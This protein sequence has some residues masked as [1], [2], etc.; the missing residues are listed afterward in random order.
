MKFLRTF[1][2]ALLAFMVGTF[3][4][5]FLWIL[6]VVGFVAMMGGAGDKVKQVTPESVLVIDCNELIVDSP[7]VDPLAGLDLMNMNSVKQLPLLKALQAIDAARSDERIEGIYLRL[8]GAGGITGAAILEELREALKE[9]KQSGKFVVS[10]N[11]IYTQGAYYLASVADKIYLQP[12]GGM[13]WNGLSA[14]VMFYKGLL[15]KLDMKVEIFRPTVCKY[16][17]AVEPYFLDR[18]SPANR[19]QMQQLID[20]SWKTIVDGVSES[21]GISVEDLNRMADN[22]EVALGEDARKLGLIDGLIYEDEMEGIF[23]DL[24]V[25]KQ[26]DG[27]YNFVTLGEYAATVGDLKHLNSDQVAVVYADGSIVDGEGVQ[28]GNIF[29]NPL[30][31]TLA[32][33]RRDEKV[34]AVVLRVNS[35]GGSALASDI[36]WREME[37]LRKEKPVVVS[38]GSYAASGGY[39]ISAPADVIVADKMTLTGSI[40]VFG[41]IPNA[42]DALKNKLGVTIDGVKSNKEGAVSLVTPMTAVQRAQILKGVDH[43]YE[44]FTSKVAQGRNLELNHVLEIAGGRVWAGSDALSIGLIDGFGGL[45]TAIALA[46]DKAGIADDFYVREVLDEPTGLAAVMQALNMSVRSHF[47]RS[48]LEGVMDDYKEIREVLS[49]RGV[50]MYCPYKFSV[51]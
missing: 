15:S 48:E 23:A 30:A 29:G 41:M 33:V 16:K 43:V 3:L 51:E 49:Q 40:G 20:S 37:L 19:E 5:S 2:A 45:K 24:G 7:S 36:I 50:V 32:G 11:E 26:A 38:M 44:T 31:E 42:H 25:E 14:D 13:E 21:R 35:P 9:F 6:C 39:Y 17:S 10:Y 1:L 12:E 46:A 18:M 22:L 28:S 4:L 8:N 34:R 47:M 27:E